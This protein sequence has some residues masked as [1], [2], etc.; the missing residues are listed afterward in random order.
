M[1]HISNFYFSSFHLHLFHYSGAWRRFWIFFV[2]T[3]MF[4]QR[5]AFLKRWVSFRKLE[6]RSLGFPRGN[7]PVQ[8]KAP[9]LLSLRAGRTRGLS[10]SGLGQRRPQELAQIG[11]RGGRGRLLQEVPRDEGL[12]R[13]PLDRGRQEG[14]GEGRVP[15]L[16][17]R[18]HHRRREAGRQV[19]PGQPGARQEIQ[20]FVTRLVGL[21][22]GAGVTPKSCEALST[23]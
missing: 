10:W 1:Y 16:R 2:A 11:P 8:A 3:H 23:T 9:L 17:P 15:P 22:D 18:R 4:S 12:H 14:E 13:L 20:R 7:N 5:T 6:A 19:L 21:V